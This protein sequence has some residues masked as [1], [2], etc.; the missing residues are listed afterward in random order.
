MNNCIKILLRRNF[1]TGKGPSKFYVIKYKSLV[2]SQPS[3]TPRLVLRPHL[4]TVIFGRFRSWRVRFIHLA[5]FFTS[6][7]LF[8]TIYDHHNMSLVVPPF[9]CHKSTR[10]RWDTTDEMAWFCKSPTRSAWSFSRE[11]A[12]RTQLSRVG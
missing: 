10:R 11:A 9:K 6:L 1:P 3:S 7:S 5:S 4:T 8:H 12:S 2:W